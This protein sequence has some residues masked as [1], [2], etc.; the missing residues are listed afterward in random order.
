LDNINV[1]AQCALVERLPEIDAIHA[2]NIC[3]V[4]WTF[5][6]RTIRYG[7]TCTCTVLYFVLMD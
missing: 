3:D 4:Q 2:N 1:Q 5:K 6:E 7:A